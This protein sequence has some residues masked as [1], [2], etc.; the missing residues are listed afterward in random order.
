[1]TDATCTTF[2]NFNYEQ[3]VIMVIV[4]RVA[5]FSNL[6]SVKSKPAKVDYLYIL[7]ETASFGKAWQGNLDYYVAG[8]HEIIQSD[9]FSEMFLDQLRSD[10]CYWAQNW[11]F[12]VQLCVA[13]AISDM[14][15]IYLST[16]TKLFSAMQVAMQ[17]LLGNTGLREP[18]VHWNNDR[19]LTN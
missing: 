9:M 17:E 4:V 3:T 13:S 8:L 2:M 12:E 10:H 1:M 16:L 6:L 5:S 11:R 19:H 7:V 18:L 14:F 15:F